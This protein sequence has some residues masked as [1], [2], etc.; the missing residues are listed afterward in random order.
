MSGPESTSS[1]RSNWPGPHDDGGWLA[2]HALAALAPM[3]LLLGEPERAVALAEEA[4]AAAHGAAEHNIVVMALTRAAETM[5]LARQSRRAGEILE[6]L[7]E[8]LHDMGSRRWLADALEMG[9]LVLESRGDLGAAV[10]VLV[11]A[12]RLRAASGE[13]GGGVRA[14]AAE[15]RAGRERLVAAVGPA[16]LAEHEAQCRNL[17]PEAAAA[18][19]LARLRAGP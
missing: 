6:E 13:Q 3:T 15:V 1:V 7:L 11:V 9:A 19:L 17:L 10:E 2:A 16:R 18:E 12:E 8:L 14:L 5:L 4:I